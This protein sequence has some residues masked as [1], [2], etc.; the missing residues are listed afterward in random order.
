MKWKITKLDRRHSG[1]NVM[2]YMIEIDRRSVP[3]GASKDE[4]IA[5]FKDMRVWFWDSYG[6]GSELAYVAI[7]MST[8]SEEPNRSSFGLPTKERWAWQ[9]DFGHMRL[10]LK[11][12]AEM[13]FFNLKF[14]G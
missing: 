12:D 7:Q 5:F 1:Y 3:I 10:Y 4:Q 6:P 9:T 8:S 2:K 11:S 14:T 13:T